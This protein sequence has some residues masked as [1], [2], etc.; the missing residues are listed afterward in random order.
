M[1]LR[2][3][4]L[5]PYFTVMLLAVMGLSSC[6]EP[7]TPGQKAL[8]GAAAGAAAGG[9]LTGHG[10]GALAG[11]AVGAG[12]GYLIGK[13]DERADRR[14]DDYEYREGRFTDRR[15]FVES[16]YYPYNVIDVRGIP[17][18]ARVVDPSVNRVFINP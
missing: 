18:G 1:S 6:D 13:L 17:H 15:G 3:R 4:N 11:A 10:R 5:L 7:M 2:M 8:A 9:L 16:P 12:A 14:A